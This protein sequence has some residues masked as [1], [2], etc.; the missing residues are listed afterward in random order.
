[1]LERIPC[2]IRLDAD[3]GTAAM[4]VLLQPYLHRREG[5]DEAMPEHLPTAGLHTAPA[6]QPY[7]LVTGRSQVVVVGGNHDGGP[8]LLL[9]Q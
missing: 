8:A 2:G 4:D 9:P 7:H 3:T 5:I 1:M 6:L